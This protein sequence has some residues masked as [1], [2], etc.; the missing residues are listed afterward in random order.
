MLNALCMPNELLKKLQDEN[1]MTEL[2]VMQE[3]LKLYP[4][5]EVWEY[6]CKECGVEPTEKWLDEVLTYEKEVLSKR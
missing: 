2:M 5:N 4:F 6:Y 1:R 3:E